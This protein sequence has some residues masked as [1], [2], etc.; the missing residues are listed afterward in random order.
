MLAK[1]GQH[2]KVFSD[3]QAGLYR[4]RSPIRQPR[5]STPDPHHQSS[6]AYNRKGSYNIPHWVP[7][8]TEIPGNELADALAKEATMEIPNSH[9]TSYALL[10][11]KIK[12]IGFSKWGSLVRKPTPRPSS[13]PATHTKNYPWKPQ[14]RTQL[15]RGINRTIANTFYQLKFGHGYPKSYL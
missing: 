11:Y 10:G 2:Y 9:E 6:P 15:P 3:N 8:H 7:G 12:Q 5:T 13:N 4:L 1:P 14:P